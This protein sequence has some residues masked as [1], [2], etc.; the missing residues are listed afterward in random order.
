M[1]HHHD[2]HA[3]SAEAAALGW[4]PAD[5]HGTNHPHGHGADG[6]HGHFIAS[7]RMLLGI[8]AALLFCT[9]LTV[10][11]AQAEVWVQNTWGITLPKWVNVWGVMSIATIKAMLV[12]MYFMGL[13]HDKPVNTYTL[14]ASLICVGLFL[15]FSMID[16]ANR[17]HIMPYKQGEIV[18]GGTGVGLASSPRDPRFDVHL[19]PKVNTAGGPLVEL[20]RE[21][22]IIGTYLGDEEAYLKKL[23]EKSH[24]GG[25]ADHGPSVSSAQRSVPRTGLSGALDTAAPADAHGD[26]HGADAHGEAAP[27]AD[28]GD[29]H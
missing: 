5:P 13:R 1:A 28:H 21:E 12:C 25:H 22:A 4:D 10:G 6:H 14:L 16:L 9:A 27:A 7:N 19:S 18:V 29:G 15:G 11:L 2:H 8:L 26:A 17:G 23:A 20:R 24:H 3:P